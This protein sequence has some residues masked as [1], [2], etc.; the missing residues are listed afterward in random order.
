MRILP[1]ALMAAFI[2][3]ATGSAFAVEVQCAKQ[4]L[5]QQLLIEKYKETPVGAGTVNQDRYM[6]I[7][8]SAKGTW[9]ILMT[10]TDG[11]S[12]IIASG[13]NWDSLPQIAQAKPTT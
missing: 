2:C 6:Q 3:A 10:Q 1:A 9:T 7:F 4:M 12:C 11:Q 13:E 8:V 5:M